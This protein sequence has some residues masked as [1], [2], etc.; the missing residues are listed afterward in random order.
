MNTKKQIKVFLLQDIIP[1]YR[2]PVFQRLAG[3]AHVDLT[4]FFGKPS[5]NRQKENLKNAEQLIGFKSVRIPLF[6]LKKSSCQIAFLK[7]I[8]SKRPD[9]VISGRLGAWDGLL[10]LFCSYW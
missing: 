7:H 6:E 8:I 9:V 3:L 2:V 5:K 4:V 1:N 10:F